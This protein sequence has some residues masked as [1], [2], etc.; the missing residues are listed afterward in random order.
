MTTLPHSPGTEAALLGCALLERESFGVAKGLVKPTDFYSPANAAIWSACGLLHDRGQPI[1]QVTIRD[2]LSRSGK[3]A[4]VGGDEYLLAIPVF[5]VDPRSVESYARTVR[6]HAKHRALATICASLAARGYSTELSFDDYRTEA[7]RA[8]REV[9][10]AEADGEPVHVRDVLHDVMADTEAIKKAGKGA[11]TGHGTGLLALDKHLGGLNEGLLYIV[12]GRPGMGK[13]AFT[14]GIVLATTG[15]APMLGFSIE[16]PNRENGRRLIASEVGMDLR[17]LATAKITGDEWRG[18]ARTCERLNR[19]PIYLDEKT[20]TLDQIVSKSRRFKAKHGA[21][22]PIVIDYLQLIQGDRKLPREQQ[23]AETTR[24]LKALAKELACPIVCLSQLNRKC[25][26]RP[27]KRPQIADLRESGAIEQDA[28]VI[29][30]LYRRG[31]YAA[32]MAKES[33]PRKPNKWEPESDIVA[34]ED[35]GITEFMI[36]K[37]RGGPTGT[38]RALFQNA[39]ARFVDLETQYG[40]EHE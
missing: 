30:F 36:A 3:L 37:M 20:R 17:D 13:S 14:T 11:I 5:N 4:A 16:M 8:I 19:L 22:G 31:Y 38:V 23:I 2:E 6:D 1:D 40:S 29:V 12:G 27:D 26:E 24:E 28:D 32:Q 39:S 10:T 15:E 34:G 35:D 7:E 25:E 18:I 33:K 21:I 9:T